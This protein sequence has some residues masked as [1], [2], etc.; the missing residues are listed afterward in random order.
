MDALQK[1]NKNLIPDEMIKGRFNSRKSLCIGI[2]K[3]N[4]CRSKNGSKKEFNVETGNI[5]I[6]YVD[7]STGIT[8]VI[9]TCNAMN[10]SRISIRQYD[11]SILVWLENHY[12][13]PTMFRSYVN[14]LLTPEDL[15]QQKAFEEQKQERED[16]LKKAHDSIPQTCGGSDTCELCQDDRSDDEIVAHKHLGSY[17]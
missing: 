3:I 5:V 9:Q 11:K 16:A 6:E 12:F 15:K 10:S 1:T 7:L 17:T 2:E 4:K 8:V 13:E 14:D